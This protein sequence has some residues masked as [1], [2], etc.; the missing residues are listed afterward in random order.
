M[1]YMDDLHHSPMKI[2][3]PFLE[4]LE[5]DISNWHD[6]AYTNQILKPEHTVRKNAGDKLKATQ[7]ELNLSIAQSSNIFKQQATSK[8]KTVKP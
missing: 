2:N 4:Q 5:D 8:Q 6:I 1:L 3:R 7:N